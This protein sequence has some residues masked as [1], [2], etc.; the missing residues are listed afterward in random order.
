MNSLSDS[1]EKAKA[2]ARDLP[3]SGRWTLIGVPLALMAGFALLLSGNIGTRDEAPVSWGKVF[4]SSELR[5]AEQALI[6]AG[7]TDFRTHGQRI[8]VP[9]AEVDAYNAALMVDGRLPGDSLS[10]FERQFDKSG[11][12]T[13]R[14]Q[15]ADLRN[16][17]LRKE[18]RK[19]LA[20]VKD[21]ESADVLWSV[22]QSG[23]WPRREKKTAATVSL[24]PRRGTALTPE[25]VASIRSAVAGMVPDLSEEDITVL[26]QS[27]GAA[28]AFEAN[29]PLDDRTQAAVAAHTRRY[30]ETISQALAYIPGALVNVSVDL[31]PV[32]REV[33]RRQSVDSKQTVTVESAETTR[34]RSSNQT[35]P[36]GEPGVASNQPGSVSVGGPLT[37]TRD[38]Q[39]D[40][41][42]R[43]VPSWT[44][45]ERELRA[46]KPEAVRVAVSIPESY[47][48]AVAA[49]RGLTRGE[50]EASKAAYAQAVDAIRLA[51]EEKVRERVAT[52]IPAGSPATAVH[53]TTVT[54]IEPDVPPLVI[55]WTESVGELV[56]RWGSTAL[57]C[58]V[59]AVGLLV[60][61]RGM[62]LPEPAPPAAL[63]ER[64]DRLAVAGRIG[65]NG[66][67][68]EDDDQPKSQRDRV[69]ELAAHDPEAVAAVLNSWLRNAA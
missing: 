19:T 35:P 63:E 50:D 23:E 46:A 58:V 20:A 8:F 59:A 7:L 57:L 48:D 1:F 36:Q 25:R 18:V 45:S 3:P 38:E 17:A 65:P 28:H 54:P 33:E 27:T 40:S 56:S 66:K 41:A 44:T 68:E 15:L 61:R 24:M 37:E 49:G 2:F 12:F 13:S 10:E 55:P 6:E 52:L 11:L 34:N 39:S 67:V 4:A 60:L 9:A 29:G 32:R 69:A 5:S 51:E 21:I 62:T 47:H 31:D 53:V 16:I 14:E 64:L 26:D 30:R 22:K 43:V 42:M